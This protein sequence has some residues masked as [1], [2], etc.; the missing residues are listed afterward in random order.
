MH[1]TGNNVIIWTQDKGDDMIMTQSKDV[2]VSQ[3]NL[4][5]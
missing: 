5:G 2:N 4:I 3:S 1:S